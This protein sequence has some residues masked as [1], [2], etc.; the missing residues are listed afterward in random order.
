MLRRKMNVFMPLG[1]L[2]LSAG[3]IL[4]F[5]SHGKVPDFAIGFLF[6]MSIVFVIAGFVKMSKGTS[7]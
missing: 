2:L 7:V 6:G 5:L 1:L 4:R 3:G